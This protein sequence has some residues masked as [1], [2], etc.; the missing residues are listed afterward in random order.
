MNNEN[1]KKYNKTISMSKRML[2][3]VRKEK[4][5]YENR[6]IFIER[7]Y[8]VGVAAQKQEASNKHLSK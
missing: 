1:C 8:W 6:S 4:P 2:D 7:M 5:D 3:H